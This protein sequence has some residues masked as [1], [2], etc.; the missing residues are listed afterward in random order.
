MGVSGVP[1]GR[2]GRGGCNDEHVAGGG[3]PANPDFVGLVRVRRCGVAASVLRGIPP[4]PQPGVCCISRVLLEFLRL[5]PEGL[6]ERTWAVMIADTIS[7]PTVARRGNP[8]RDV[9]PGGRQVPRRA[10]DE[11]PERGNPANRQTPQTIRTRPSLSREKSRLRSIRG[12]LLAAA[13]PNP[14]FC[15]MPTQ[16]DHTSAAAGAARTSSGQDRTALSAGTPAA[17]RSAAAGPAV[18]AEAGPPSRDPWRRR[19]TRPR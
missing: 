5:L 18:R 3:P 9:A 4:G 12:T 13:R 1:G 17:D 14:V 11:Q 2:A 10:E 15:A 7:N 19:G 16:P 8:R 6:D